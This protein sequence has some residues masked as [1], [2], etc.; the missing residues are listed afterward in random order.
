MLTQV[1]LG[2]RGETRI[3]SNEDL[4]KVPADAIIKVETVT[5]P[6]FPKAKPDGA[7]YKE[8]DDAFTAAVLRWEADKAEWETL[9]PIDDKVKQVSL[10]APVFQITKATFDGFEV[11]IFHTLRG[12]VMGIVTSEDSQKAFLHSPCFIDP[13]IERGRVHYLPLA[14][15][16]FEF[17]ISRTNCVGESIPQLAELMGYPEFVEAN[18]RGFY[19]FR[20]RAA[21]HHIEADLPE[22]APVLSVSADVRAHQEG[23]LPTSDTREEKAIAKA[24]VINAQQSTPQS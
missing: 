4:A 8:G 12:P 18:R 16:G 1:I 15:A 19:Q 20:M 14:F 7:E 2:R 11:K 21:Y 17:M 24:R 23:L 22:E 9:H 13:N 5:P 6:E 3:L 10:W